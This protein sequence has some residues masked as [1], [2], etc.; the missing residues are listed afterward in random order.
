MIWASIKKPV[1][2]GCNMAEK[3]VGFVSHYFNHIQVTAIEITEGEL[4]VGDTIRFKGHTTDF[5]QVVDSMQIEHAN[6]QIAK[7]GDSIGMKVKDHTRQH[8]EVFVVTED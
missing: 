3:K 6:V 8:D 7:K 2:E 5:T 1:M 4:K